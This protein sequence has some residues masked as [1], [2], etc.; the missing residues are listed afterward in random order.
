[1]F[2]MSKQLRVSINKCILIVEILSVLCDPMGQ[3]QWSHSLEL[4]IIHFL[5][6]NR[7]SIPA[8]GW[9]LLLLLQYLQWRIALRPSIQ[10]MMPS[11]YTVWCRL[12]AMFSTAI[13]HV[14]SKHVQGSVSMQKNTMCIKCTKQLQNLVINELTIQWS[15]IQTL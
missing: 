2:D 3:L 7:L 6:F 15:K 8:V 4:D 11:K 9:N 12:L 13:Y 10:K 1:M 5:V 14:S